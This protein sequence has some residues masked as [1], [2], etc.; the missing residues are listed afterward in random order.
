MLFSSTV[1]THDAGPKT[2]T[3][4]Q[5]KTRSSG[6]VRI[7]LHRG[8]FLSRASFDVSS[9]V[10]ILLSRRP[11]RQV[12]IRQQ[13]PPQLRSL[14]LQS[15]QVRVRRIDGMT[16][17]ER[18]ALEE[19][20]AAIRLHTRHHD[21]YEEWER[22]TRRDALVSLFPPPLHTCS[23]GYLIFMRYVPVDT[24]M[25]SNTNIYSIRPAISA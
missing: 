18:R 25:P 7:M 19:T 22:D 24:C 17:A 2:V 13:S 5:L 12:E 6:S 9:T 1:L 21:P 14:H 4:R 3:A 23:K 15:K 16:P 8:R 20:V 10:L 11:S